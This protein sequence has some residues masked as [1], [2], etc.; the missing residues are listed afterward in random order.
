MAGPGE[1]RVVVRG[2]PRAACYAALPY[3]LGA[4]AVLVVERDG[5]VALV[6]F[7]MGVARAAYWYAVVARRAVVETS[8]GLAYR[9]TGGGGDTVRWAD[10]R[11]IRLLEGDWLPEWPRWSMARFPRVRVIV[12]GPDGDVSGVELGE[13][14]L[15]T[16]RGIDRAARDLG[17]VAARHGVGFVNGFD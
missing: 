12:S 8:E 14:L 15:R 9:G 3:I 17:E 6:P 2:E 10:V 1:S 11:E 13:V 16:R 5:W 7:A 4:L